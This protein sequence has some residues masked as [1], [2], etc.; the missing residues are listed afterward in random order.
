MSGGDRDEVA[1]RKHLTAQ[2]LA[3]SKARDPVDVVER[4][5]AVQGQ[6]PRGA[7]LSIRARSRG[8]KASDIDHALTD[9]R[10]LVISWLNRGTLHLVRSVD[11]HW[12]HALTAPT[13]VAGTARRLAQEGISPALAERGVRTIRRSLSKDGPLTRQELRERLDSAGVPARGQALV[14][15]LALA[16]IRAYVVRGPM[17]GKEHAYV[18]VEDW[19][20]PHKPISRE[21]ALGEL[22]RRYLAGHGPASDRDLARWAGLPLRD[23]R[24]A[25]MHGGSALIERGGLFELRPVRRPAKMPPPTLLGSYDPLL[26]G[27]ESREAVLGAHKRLVTVNGLFRPFA[28]VDGEAAATWRLTGSRL[29]IEPL[30]RLDSAQ[31]GALEAESKDVLRFLGLDGSTDESSSI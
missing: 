13:L 27:W 30:R 26:L 1:H 17:K 29:T 16:T 21:L 20:E 5:L 8:L 9:D 28:L 24:A 12:L 15:L 11:F 10:S 19:L 14:H 2:M 25:L 22:A 6:D 4:L 18:L 23:A 7:R 31:S 3:G